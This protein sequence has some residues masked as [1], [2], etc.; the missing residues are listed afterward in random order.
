MFELHAIWALNYPESLWGLICDIV[1]FVIISQTWQ[2]RKQQY[3]MPSESASILSILVCGI[4]QAA[5]VEQHT[6]EGSYLRF[7]KIT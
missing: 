2:R 3:Q 1:F 5:S 4:Y 7:S 6:N